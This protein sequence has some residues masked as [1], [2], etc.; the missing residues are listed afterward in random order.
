MKILFIDSESTGLPK[1]YNASYEDVDNWPR[2][3]SL[4]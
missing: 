2:V 3:I 1:Q 4:A